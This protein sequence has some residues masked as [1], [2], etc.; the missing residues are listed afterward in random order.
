MTVKTDLI[1]LIFLFTFTQGILTN[2]KSR[3]NNTIVLNYYQLCIWNLMS[4][5]RNGYLVKGLIYEELLTGCD[6]CNEQLQ[7]HAK[8]IVNYFKEDPL[9]NQF[10][11][12]YVKAK[13]TP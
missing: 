13:I 10:I 1:I 5:N 3:F 11:L 4:C 12:N 8:E 9:F 7:I 2:Y 6:K